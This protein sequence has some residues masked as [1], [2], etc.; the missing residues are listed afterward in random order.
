[1]ERVTKDVLDTMRFDHEWHKVRVNLLMTA[2]WM[3]AEVNQFLKPYGLTQQQFNTL[4]IL[5]GALPNP[6]STSH[7]RE[8]LIDKMSDTSRLTDRL[9]QKGWVRKKN[10]DHD[11]RLV[12]IWITETGLDL[13]NR[14]DERIANLDA[15]TRDLTEDE[16]HQLNT[17]LKKIRL[18]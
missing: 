2:A 12:N 10:C 7:L 11:G 16:A 15:L 6:I 1:M 8:K 4:R 14:I 3:K 9:A 18:R 5:R 17:L 13:L